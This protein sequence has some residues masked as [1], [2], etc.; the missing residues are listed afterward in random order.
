MIRILFVDDDPRILEGMRRMLHGMRQQWDIALAGGGEQALARL[1]EEPFDV[2]VSDM[3]MPGMNGA[4]LLRQV[5]NRHP[6][7]ARIVLSGHADSDLVMQAFGVA[8]QYLAKPCDR[9]VL[10]QTIERA[11]M[12]K[13]RLGSEEIARA[14]GGMAGLP[15]LPAVYQELVTY[16]KSPAATIDHVGEILG[17]DLA[18]TTAILK[19]V[20]SAYFGL[21]R[22][23]S[24]IERAASFLGLDTI[25][26][27]VLEHGLFNDAPVVEQDGFDHHRLRRHS[28]LTGSIAR[29]IAASHD[30]THDA[31][32]DAFLAGVLHDIGQLALAIARPGS[33]AEIQEVMT[34]RR[35]SRPEAEMAVVQATH[36]EVGA[37]LLGTWGFSDSV[38]ESVLLHH[39]P[40]RAS[41]GEWGLA[42]IVH[43]ATAVADHPQAS[44][45][46]D[47]LLD[48]D[49]DYLA[50]SGVASRWPQWR[51]A[52]LRIAEPESA[53]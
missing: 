42:G 22:P 26:T 48:V 14:V 17:T 2:V 16:L 45:L 38:V 40:A 50:A 46:E 44:V 7:V 11:I 13:T 23:I 34:S 41:S 30:E 53:P 24:R 6:R 28:L 47:P 9:I 39:E 8:Q 35:M 51:E 29:A 52:C 19:I 49:R 10:Q 20:N 31:Q 37:Y 3:K 33:S 32:E 12:L 1:G 25:M 27:L 43:V 18:M 5:K 15:A 21:Q 36:G 4:E